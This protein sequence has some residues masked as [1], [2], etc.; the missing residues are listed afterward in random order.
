MVAR[1]SEERGG[2]RQ[3]DRQRP[4]RKVATPPNDEHDEADHE[5]CLEHESSHARADVLVGRGRQQRLRGKG[6]GAVRAPVETVEAVDPARRP[7]EIPGVRAVE[8]GAPDLS[9]AAAVG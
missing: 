6:D 8:G 5:P 3:R 1:R 4:E 7:G 9:L 2:H